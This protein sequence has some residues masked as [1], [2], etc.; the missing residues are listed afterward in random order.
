LNVDTAGTRLAHPSLARQDIHPRNRKGSVTQMFDR[1]LCAKQPS[2]LAPLHELRGTPKP[3]IRTGE[4]W[5]VQRAC[6]GGDG[7]RARA[8]GEGDTELSLWHGKRAVGG[9]GAGR[10]RVDRFVW[11]RTGSITLRGFSERFQAAKAD[12]ATGGR[13]G[14]ILG[15]GATGKTNSGKR[16]SW[17]LGEVFTDTTLQWAQRR[18]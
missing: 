12:S 10:S 3:G 9:V 13:R 7:G 6:R 17:K 18:P 16:G 5:D 8:G 2:K 11:R 4:S 1:I 15:E 14:P